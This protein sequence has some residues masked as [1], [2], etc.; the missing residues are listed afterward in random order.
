VRQAVTRGN[1]AYELVW[2]GRKAEQLLA[3]LT[4][5]PVGTMTRKWQVF[6]KHQA[7]QG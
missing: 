3:V 2:L 5:V 6:A 7:R 1:T 4:Q